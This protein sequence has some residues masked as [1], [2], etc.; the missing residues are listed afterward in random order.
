[1]ESDQSRWLAIQLERLDQEVRVIQHLFED[2]GPD[3]VGELVHRLRY[4]AS[5]AGRIADTIEKGSE[6]ATSAAQER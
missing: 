2:D 1:M 6:A 3:R 5:S 4:L